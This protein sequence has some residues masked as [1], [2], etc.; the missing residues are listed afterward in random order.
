M[1][2]EVLKNWKP[3]ATLSIYLH[4][5]EQDQEHFVPLLH[6]FQLQ[7]LLNSFT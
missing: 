5:G 6:V 1:Q 7:I 3:K 2:D 4:L